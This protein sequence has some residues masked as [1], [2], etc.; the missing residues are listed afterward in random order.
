MFFVPG[1]V[2]F[3]ANLSA[4][5]EAA[6]CAMLAEF[7]YHACTAGLSGPLTQAFRVAEPRWVAALGVPLLSLALE[8]ALHCPTCTR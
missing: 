7:A 3:A 8:F 4:G 6:R 2:F 1:S 5:V